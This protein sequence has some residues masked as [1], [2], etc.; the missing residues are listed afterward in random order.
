MFGAFKRS[1]HLAKESFRVLRKDPELMLLTAASFV[2]VAIIAILAVAA[3]FITGAIDANSETVINATGIL[4]LAVAYFIGYFII[5]YFQVALVSS[6]QFRLSGGDPNVRYGISQAN[7]HLGAI[8]SWTVIAATVGLI[9]RILESAARGRDGAGR[10][11]GMI[12]LSIIGTAWGLLV[13]FVIPVIAAEGVGGFEAIRRS[14]RIVKHRWG[15]A[16]VGNAGMGLLIGLLLVVTTGPLFAIG[17]A[18]FTRSGDGNALMGGL[19]IALAIIVALGLMVFSA[20]LNSTYRAVLYA[21]A[22]NNKTGGFSKETLDN[23]FRTNRG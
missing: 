19:F 5:I 10:I 20:S 21:Y 7:K 2:G 1:F 4:V 23:A 12:I 22:T 14:S 18:L 15:E 8:L 16:I 17:A 6:V 13:F 9:L 11:I 3:G